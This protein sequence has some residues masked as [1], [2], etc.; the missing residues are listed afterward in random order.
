MG[1]TFG[2]I[3]RFGPES[4]TFFYEHFTGFATAALLMSIIQG[5]YVYIASFNQGKLLALGGNT[6]NVVYDVSSANELPI[7]LRNA[8][9]HWQGTEPVDR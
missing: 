5:L 3:W 6:G 2:Y 1:C 4:F 8:V 7:P 9:F